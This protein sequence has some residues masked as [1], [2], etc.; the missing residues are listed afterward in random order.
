MSTKFSKK[1]EQL[2]LLLEFP[3]LYISN[4]FSDLRTQIDLA[5]FAKEL[6]IN[7]SEQLIELRKYWNDMIYKLNSFEE[8]C[9]IRRSITKFKELTKETNQ[10]FK[11]VESKLDLIKQISD[12]EQSNEIILE[13]DD[14]VYD[15]LA[16]IEKILF[17]NKT[18]IFL[19]KSEDQDTKRIANY[20]K[21]WLLES[22]LS[23]S[24][25]DGFTV[26]FPMEF[27]W[28]IN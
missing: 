13:L 27:L 6:A 11:L 28:E 4:Y 8:K 2:K 14:L 16:K 9:L 22:R 1:L 17:L 3:R 25:H 26:K 24:N 23:L 10:M 5:F 21:L 7:N 15:E 12:E 20:L 18:I 19:N